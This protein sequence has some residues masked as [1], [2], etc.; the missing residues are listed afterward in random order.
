[1]ANDTIFVQSNRTDNRVVLWEVDP[2]HPNGEAYVA[3]NFVDGVDRNPPVEVAKTAFVMSKLGP[4]GELRVVE[5]AEEAA[6]LQREADQDREDR[7]AEARAALADAADD[8][9]AAQQA[10]NE[11]LASENQRLLAELSAHRAQTARA[12]A[13]P[14]QS[15]AD[16]SSQ[17]ASQNAASGDSERATKPDDAKPAPRQA[18]APAPSRQQRPQ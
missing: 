17:D 12:S 7:A 5:S 15:A 9:L 1:V 3:G 11:R 4:S 6:S 10:E 18:S 14:D 13:S 8:K 2:A 16:E